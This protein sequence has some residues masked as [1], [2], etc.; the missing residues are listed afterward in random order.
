VLLLLL[1]SDDNGTGTCVFR[2][3]FGIDERIHPL[4]PLPELTGEGL[5]LL[6]STRETIPNEPNL[7]V[8]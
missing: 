8:V 4:R 6:A 7:R 5:F 3:S 2:S 1:L